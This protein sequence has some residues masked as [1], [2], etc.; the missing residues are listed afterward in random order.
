MSL[1]KTRIAARLIAVAALAALT[2]GCFQPMYAER[3][4]GKPGKLDRH[5]CG[6]TRD[7]A[8]AAPVGY[9]AAL[10]GL[11]PGARSTAAPPVPFRQAKTE[12]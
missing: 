12:L 10:S 8:L 3:N 6:K 4:D 9:R 2:A 5:V 7:D 1:A 11:T